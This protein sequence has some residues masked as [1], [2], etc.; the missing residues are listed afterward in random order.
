M[1]TF[2]PETPT[3]YVVIA[4]GV[5]L[6]LFIFSTI[7]NFM[8]SVACKQEL[9]EQIGNTVNS[10]FVSL[11]PTITNTERSIGACSYSSINLALVNIDVTATAS[12][13]IIAEIKELDVEVDVQLLSNGKQ[14]FSQKMKLSD[15]IETNGVLRNQENFNNMII[16]PQHPITKDIVL[17]IISPDL[18]EYTV[19]ELQLVTFCSVSYLLK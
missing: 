18:S 19:N 9:P 3:D 7:G 12:T 16:N 6:A 14:L 2:P 13:E 4:V 10:A 15:G 1:I 5:I 8:M 11:S 17:R